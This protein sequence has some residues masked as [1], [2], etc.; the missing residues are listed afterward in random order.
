MMFRNDFATAIGTGTA[1]T[2]REATVQEVVDN[3]EAWESTLV[4]L[5]EVTISG[6]ATFNGGTT[7]SDGSGS[8]AMFTRSSSS[9]AATPLPAGAVDMVAIVSEFNDP[10]IGLRN[11]DDVMGDISNPG[12]GTDTLITIAEVRALFSGMPMNLPAN[13]KIEGVVISDKDNGNFADQNVVIQDETGGIVVRFGGAHNL[14]LGT[15]VDVS[16][17]NLELSEFRG[18]LQ[19]NN[20]P[21]ANAMDMGA[22]SLPEPRIATVQE[23]IDNQNTLESTLVLIEGATISGNDIFDGETSVTDASGATIPMFTRS[24]ASFANEMVPTN[25]VELAII[26]SDFEGPQITMRNLE[27]LEG[28]STENPDN[29]DNPGDPV[30]N[31]TE[32]FS[33]YSNDE[34]I[35]KTGWLN[36]ATKGTR[37][38]RAKEFSGNLYAQATAFNDSNPE[39]E[40]WLITPSINL[41]EANT[42]SFESAQ[43]FYTHDG[44]AVF[45]S[46]D[47][48]GA[49]VEAATWIELPAALAGSDSESNVWVPSGDIDLSAY[50]G[51][52]F[53][54]FRHT[55]NNASGT[56]SYRIDN[57]EI[58]N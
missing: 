47:F 21:L 17:S 13:R 56:T 35:M 57:I 52:G 14:S 4:L 46:I 8:I 54:G 42:L 45:I 41:D 7:V 19:V 44:L 20:T 6:S 40:A 34:D 10:Q 26:V 5:K 39:M 50:S 11:I 27:D 16:I 37:I 53:I 55:G 31:L 2:P 29:P 1:P 3:Q 9:F 48:D 36:V 25:T 28:G 49:N 58:K 32:D 30:S 12:S 33:G 51:T 15:A 18:L 38:W 22:G 23:I 43:A 24:T